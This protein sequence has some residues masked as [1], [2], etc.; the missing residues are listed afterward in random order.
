M[1][2]TGEHL[3]DGKL[4]SA[5][6]QGTKQ[7]IGRLVEAEM[8]SVRHVVTYADWYSLANLSREPVMNPFA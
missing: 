7:R 5:A 6:T 3:L 1:F 8:D 2:G 4:I